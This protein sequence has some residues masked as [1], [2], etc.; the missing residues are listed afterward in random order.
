MPRELILGR[1]ATVRRGDLVPDSPV[2]SPTGPPPRPTDCPDLDD[3]IDRAVRERAVT[4]ELVRQLRDALGDVAAARANAAEL[5]AL[6]T[7]AGWL[8]GH[9][10]VALR[11]VDAAA[12]APESVRNATHDALD[13]L[14]T[15]HRALADQLARARSAATAAASNE[16]VEGAELDDR[17]RAAAHVG[18]DVV[19]LRDFASWVGRWLEFGE[20]TGSF[21]TGAPPHPEFLRGLQPLVR[22]Y[23]ELEDARPA[24]RLAGYPPL[25]DLLA[26]LD[27]PTDRPTDEPDDADPPGH[28]RRA[29]LRRRAGEPLPTGDDADDAEVRV[30]LGVELSWEEDGGRVTVRTVAL[31]EDTSERVRPR[32]DVPVLVDLDWPAA[33][34]LITVTRTAR[35]GANGTPA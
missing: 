11:S 8:G 31:E 24:A 5:E 22:R 35:D 1:V 25:A 17:L 6:R 15:R 16:R 29:V 14:V 7:F 2:N 32:S 21:T 20:P 3:L 33:N 27:S 23:A 19:V 18:G 4:A 12:T 13:P 30:A 9:L 28:L 10:D 26:E 34:R